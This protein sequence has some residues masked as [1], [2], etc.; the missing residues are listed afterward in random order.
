MKSIVEG[1]DTL[2]S[3]LIKHLLHKIGKLNIH[4]NCL[5]TPY[6]DAKNEH[7]RLPD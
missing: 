3:I 4:S 7:Q 1:K 2:D 6:H 5:S